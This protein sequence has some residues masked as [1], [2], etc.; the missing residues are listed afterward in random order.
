MRGAA[1]QENWERRFAKY[2]AEFPELAAE[3]ERR[4]VKG[5]LPASWEASYNFV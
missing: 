5:E 4:V 3:F 2:Q 1:F